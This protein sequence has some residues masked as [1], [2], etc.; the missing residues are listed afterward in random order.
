MRLISIGLPLFL[1]MRLISIG[2]P[3]FLTIRLISHNEAYFY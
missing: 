3:L 1:T 2:L